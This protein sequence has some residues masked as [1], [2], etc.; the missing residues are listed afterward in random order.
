MDVYKRLEELGITLPPPPAEGGVYTPAIEFGDNLVYLSGCGPDRA[1][2]SMIKGK[3]GRDLSLED[4]QEAARLCIINLLSVLDNKLGD[5][6]RIRRFVKL[7]AF[8]NSTE[9]YE[10]QPQVVNGGSNLLLELFGKE[11]G[12]PARAAIGANSL[13]EGIAVEIEA[14]VELEK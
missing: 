2:G 9:D 13:P 1:D 5:L 3:L 14:L 10:E 4:G 6:N 11:K 12:L 8:V 7:L